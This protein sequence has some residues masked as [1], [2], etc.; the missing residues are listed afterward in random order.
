MTDA[1]NNTINKE[2]AVSARKRELLA[3]MLKKRGIRVDV[4]HAI[5]KRP[6]GEPCPL[7]YAQQRLWYL[8][9]DR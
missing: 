9:G 8:G 6:E 1:V 3:K 7:S 4:S 5:P 2:N